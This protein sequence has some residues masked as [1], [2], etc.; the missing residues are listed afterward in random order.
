VV[1]AGSSKAHPLSRIDAGHD[2][3]APPALAP[4]TRHVV[5]SRRL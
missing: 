2:G 4:V 5:L 1:I 3:A